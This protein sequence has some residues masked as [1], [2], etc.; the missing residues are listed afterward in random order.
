MGAGAGGGSESNCQDLEESDSGAES[1]SWIGARLL[2]GSAAGSAV[3]GARLRGV[4]LAQRPPVSPWRPSE[5][6]LESA[7]VDGRAIS[8]VRHKW[9]RGW[10]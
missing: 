7:E 3:F 2:G 1:R 6:I 8:V 10:R 9:C 5:A 4:E